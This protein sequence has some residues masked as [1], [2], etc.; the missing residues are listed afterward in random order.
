M[1]KFKRTKL[2][3]KLKSEHRKQLEQRP[4][5]SLL[6]ILLTCML[7]LSI[8]NLINPLY[9]YKI[10]FGIFIISAISG[11]ILFFYH[12]VLSHHKMNKTAQL[13]DSE[14]DA[15]N[16][17]E[18]AWELH[19]SN[20]PLKQRQQQDTTEFYAAHKF[21]NWGI[22]R[23]L[24]VAILLLISGANATILKN[25]HIRFQKASA[26]RQKTEKKKEEKAVENAEKKREKT[27]EDYAKLKIIL[28]EEEIRAK[29]MD[30][31][32]WAGVG[33]SSRGFTE[34]YL[35]VFIN[36]KFVK[37]IFPDS[38]PATKPGKLKVKG[39]MAL[40]EFHVKPYD[41]I[42]YHLTAYSDMNNKKHQK[43]ISSPQFI[44][45]RPFREDAVLDKDIA[46]GQ[47]QEMLK[48][49]I[50]FLRLQVEINKATFRARIM[51]QQKF[52]KA[53]R[54]RFWKFFNAVKSEQNKLRSEV[55]D[56]LNSKIARKFPADSINNVEKAANEIDS[57][58][59]KLK[60]II[61]E[62]ENE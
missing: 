1:N 43:V 20:H 30:E 45:V 40:D 9:S 23:L 17:L 22:I 62:K 28:P 21:S 55:E 14:H 37:D 54:D 6:L 52:D 24:L 61:Q 19:K 29:P 4:L 31:I 35:S 10:A 27:V 15:Q 44:E 47:G 33:E 56:F 34:I 57:C 48:I 58:C 7:L 38:N 8:L 53:T 18:T 32:E 26:K 3:K 39:F 51:R 13:I 25:Q 59:F 41:L 46:N 12:Y 16:R 60:K 42:S 50:R 11:V 36:G 2:H 49:L 5:S